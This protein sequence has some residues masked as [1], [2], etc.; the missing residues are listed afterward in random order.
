MWTKWVVWCLLLRYC[1]LFSYYFT[2]FVFR[3]MVMVM[4]PNCYNCQLSYLPGGANFKRIWTNYRCK[5]Y[6]MTSQTI[7]LIFRAF[8]HYYENHRIFEYRFLF[9]STKNWFPVPF[10]SIC[11]WSFEIDWEI[12]QFKFQLTV[13]YCITIVW[14]AIGWTGVKLAILCF[15]LG[16]GSIL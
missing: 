14:S 7:W 4:C 11:V 8:F 15:F 1:Y 2:N 10:L 13:H 16:L 3:N 9:Y 5:C 12:F 6:Y